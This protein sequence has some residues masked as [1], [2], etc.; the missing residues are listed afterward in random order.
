MRLPFGWQAV[1][2]AVV[3]RMEGPMN[4]DLEL[5]KIRSMCTI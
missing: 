1:A 3:I 4:S 2:F 5:R